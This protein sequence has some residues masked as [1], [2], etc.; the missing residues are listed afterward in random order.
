MKAVGVFCHDPLLSDR[1]PLQ[2]DRFIDTYNSP[3]ISDKN[4]WAWKRKK[5]DAEPE[6][7][8]LYSGIQSTGGNG[9]IKRRE[10]GQ[11]TISRI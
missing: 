8:A 2:R 6:K 9:D 7:E 5:S 3:M 1:F 11:P 4:L 10:D